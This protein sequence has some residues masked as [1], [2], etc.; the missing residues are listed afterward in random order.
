MNPSN[1]PQ[2]SMFDR[3]FFAPIRRWTEALCD[4]ARRDR[5]AAWSIVGFVVLWTLYGVLAKGS[6][7]IHV[8]MAELA[9]LGRHP[10]LGNA[11][12][13]PFAMWLTG[14]WFLVFPRADW[15]FY[16]LGMSG[17]GIALWAAWLTSGRILAGD[18]RVLAL[19]L[20]GFIPLLTFHPLKFNNNALMIPLWA[21]AVLFVVRS[22]DDK[23][24]I[25]AALAGVFA[26]LALLTKYWSIMLI[27]GLALA[28]ISDRRRNSYFASAAPWVTVLCGALVLAPHLLW[29]FANGFPSFNYALIVHGGRT[30]ASSLGSMAGYFAGAVAYG[31]IPIAIAWA[32]TRP[33]RAAIAHLLVPFDDRRRFVAITFATMLLLP[34]PI[35]LAV[36]SQITSLWTMPA[37]TLF[38]L[39]L[40]SPAAIGISRAALSRVLAL[41]VAMPVLAVLI[42]P[43]IAFVIHRQG[44]AGLS[45]YYQPL[46]AVVDRIWRD[47]TAQPL[48]FVGGDGELAYGTAFYLARPATVF[49]D[50]NRQLAPWVDPSELALAGIVMVCPAS[51]EQCIERSKGYAGNFPRF[52][53]DEVTIAKRYLGIE[54]PRRNFVIVTVPPRNA[55]AQANARRVGQ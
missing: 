8:D 37:W 5:T 39:V 47:A 50:G 1:M 53:V 29:L 41:A 33:S 26:A 23:R 49:P 28:A 31:L 15:S 9:E 18:K 42:A 21:L 35:A 52:G 25:A 43:G 38:P 55:L 10:A 6:Q 2:P 12:N 48:Q 54:G 51:E 11:K 3:T 45:G 40:L 22:F 14:L 20:L 36:N 17:V 24:L 44:L 32:A 4:P 13:P 27:A 34:I 19:A 46:A 16:L 7:G 30:L